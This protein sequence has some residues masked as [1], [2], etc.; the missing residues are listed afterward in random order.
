MFSVI[1]ISLLII[2][3]YAAQILILEFSFGNLPLSTESFI[4]WRLW[5]EI[6]TYEYIIMGLSIFIGLTY[7]ILGIFGFSNTNSFRNMNSNS[8]SMIIENEVKNSK[9]FRYGT[10]LVISSGILIL[11]G[12]IFNSSPRAI[13]YSLLPFIQGIGIF[14]NMATDYLLALILIITTLASSVKFF[15]SSNS[16]I[17]FWLFPIIWLLIPGVL[18]VYSITIGVEISLSIDMENANNII[19]QSDWSISSKVEMLPTFIDWTMWG[20]IILS[21]VSTIAIVACLSADSFLRNDYN[22]S[23]SS[24]EKRENKSIM[25]TRER[26]FRGY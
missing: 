14:H 6:E 10:T 5:E 21:G 18:A 2:S 24:L 20:S 19:G 11:V 25:N 12:H 7:L 13:D 3:Y 22:G 16:S 17:K 26:I 1:W 23:N 9:P 4:N 8:N 15:K